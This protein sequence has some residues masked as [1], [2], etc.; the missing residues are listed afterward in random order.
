MI[1]KA[2][3][4]S[5]FEIVKK[6]L[7]FILKAELENQKILQGFN[8][9]INLF[10]DRSIPFDK[11]EVLVINIR[12]DTLNKSNQGQHG[13]HD[14]ITYNVDVYATAKQSQTETGDEKSTSIRDK[15][16]ALI[17]AILQ[18]NVYLTL[19]LDPGLIMSSNVENIDT[20]E[21]SNNQDANFVSMTRLN[22]SV[23]IYQDY[24]VWEGV[25]ADQNL[26]DVKLDLT[27]LGYKYQ[28]K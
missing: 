25:T 20:Y 3:P 4:E 27:E 15:F 12:F 16:I 28:L 7:G 11:S 2:I 1:S 9:P 21:A 17:A 6:R 5:G 22:Y 14:T 13:S 18:S 8:Y 19:G 24:S 26:T 23:R 10:V